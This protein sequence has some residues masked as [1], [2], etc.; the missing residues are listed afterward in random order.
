MCIAK[1]SAVYS[2]VVIFV[3]CFQAPAPLRTAS[4]RAVNSVNRGNQ[5]TCPINR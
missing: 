1:E 4:M 3:Y 5:C 2:F